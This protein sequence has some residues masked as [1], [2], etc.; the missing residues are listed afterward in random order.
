MS[1]ASTRCQRVFGGN[2]NVER[3]PG[4]GHISDT[5]REFADALEQAGLIQYSRGNISILDREGLEEGACECYS[6]IC[7]ET[8]NM[9]GAG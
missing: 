6:T 2:Q 8:D 7:A 4:L 5:G 9:M 1:V 3:L